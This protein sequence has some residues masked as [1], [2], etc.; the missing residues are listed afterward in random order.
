MA[1]S[2]CIAFI[3]H[4]QL[5]VKYNDHIGSITKRDRWPGRGIRK[6]RSCHRLLN[7]YKIVEGNSPQIR[8]KHSES[9]GL[10]QGA[11][12]RAW[13]ASCSTSG[14]GRQLLRRRRLELG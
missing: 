5:E 11:A 6:R 14:G 1:A 10:A 13:C 2:S 8:Q 12:C 4:L 9:G 3:A 7:R